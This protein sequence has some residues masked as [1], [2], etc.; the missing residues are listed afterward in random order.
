MAHSKHNGMTFKKRRNTISKTKTKFASGSR[1][2]SGY[3]QTEQANSSS[4]QI[5]IFDDGKQQFSK[6]STNAPFK[7]PNADTTYFTKE[8]NAN[9]HNQASL[10]E[11]PEKYLQRKR[12]LYHGVH[13]VP[14]FNLKI[15]NKPV[16][17]SFKFNVFRMNT[18]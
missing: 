17:L 4:R 1:N 6:I 5:M 10:Q 16:L 2:P 15:S 11:S 14:V 8:A 9:Q 7:R 13:E 18:N 3:L 12:N